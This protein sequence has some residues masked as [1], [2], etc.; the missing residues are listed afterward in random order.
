MHVDWEIS[1]SSKHFDHSFGGESIAN[2]D[3]NN[4]STSFRI[5]SHSE[6][7]DVTMMAF[8]RS[9]LQNSDGEFFFKVIL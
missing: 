2:F 1:E 7:E 5:V 4:A 3:L 6:V 9:M 8:L